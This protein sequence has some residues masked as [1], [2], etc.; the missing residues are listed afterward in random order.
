MGRYQYTFNDKD[1]AFF[2]WNHVR[3]YL[4]SQGKIGLLKGIHKI[5]TH[6]FIVDGETLHKMFLAIITKSQKGKRSKV[7]IK[8]LGERE[9]VA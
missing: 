4:N 2:I 6:T 9:K 8:E 7:K 5:D 3:S 1:Q